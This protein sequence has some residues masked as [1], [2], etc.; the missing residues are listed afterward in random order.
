MQMLYFQLLDEPAE[1]YCNEC[2]SYLLKEQVVWTK[3]ITGTD[4]SNCKVAMNTRRRDWILKQILNV[5]R[6]AIDSKESSLLFPSASWEFLEYLPSEDISYR[7]PE[8]LGMH[9]V[10]DKKPHLLAYSTKEKKVM[11]LEVTVK[12][13]HWLKLP[14]YE[15][16]FVNIP[17]IYQ[18]T[19]EKLQQNGFD[20]KFKYIEIGCRGIYCQDLYDLF[21]EDFQMEHDDILETMKDMSVGTLRFLYESYNP[22]SIIGLKT[23]K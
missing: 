3:H 8:V 6:D 9:E 22:S 23:E 10:N 1:V 2:D 11:V 18:K 21:E 7:W 19:I 5:M 15:Q 14:L 17:T 4:G 12:W 16:V 20:V 13:E